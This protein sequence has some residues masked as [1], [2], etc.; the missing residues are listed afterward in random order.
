MKA[1][2]YALLYDQSCN[3]SQ[4]YLNA[5]IRSGYYPTHIV[6]MRITSKL[7]KLNF[8]SD[9]F[10][11]RLSR[12]IKGVYKGYR[13]WGYRK[14]KREFLSLNE[15]A[16]Y[17]HKVDV[18]SCCDQYVSI[19]VD[20]VNDINLVSYIE[21]LDVDGVIYTSGGI[22]K[23][24]RLLAKNVLHIH[25]GIIPQVRGSDGLLW[26]VL[27]R[28]MIGESC[29]FMG[30]EIDEGPL[31]HQKEYSILPLPKRYLDHNIGMYEFVIDYYDPFFRGKL[32]EEVLGITDGLSNVVVRNRSDRESVEYY[33]MH[34]Q[35]RGKA[36]EKIFTCKENT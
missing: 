34:S 1:L 24:A 9:G 2:H 5:M 29:F 21:N 19:S 33:T 14:M 17:F 20:S 36:F 27:T 26:S 16:G 7:R 10:N 23:N 35:L 32:L 25:P 4:V 12:L 6:E 3:C 15:V 31:I 8:L 13:K 22:V 30:A 28:E 18:Q 11:R